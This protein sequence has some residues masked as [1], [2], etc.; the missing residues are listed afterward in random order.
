MRAQGVVPAELSQSS[1]SRPQEALRSW[2]AALVHLV[3]AASHWVYSENR[4]LE[5]A[6]LKTLLVLFKCFIFKKFYCGHLRIHLREESVTNHVC[7]LHS[8][9]TCSPEPVSSPSYIFIIIFSP[10]SSNFSDF[11]SSSSFFFWSLLKEIP[12]TQNF[13]Q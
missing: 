12:D 2:L 6:Q 8:F 9:R 4:V 11:S 10:S 3:R 1:V 7:L 5:A 13:Y